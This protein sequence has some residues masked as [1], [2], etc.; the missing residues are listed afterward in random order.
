MS[1]LTWNQ[2]KVRNLMPLGIWMFI[3]G[4]AFMNFGVGVLAMQYFPGAVER[5]GFPII[6]I[7]LFVFIL[8]AN[9][10]MRKS[11]PAN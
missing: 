9:G 4:R 8:G 1:L 3:L 5:L 6:I 2:R 7:G 10:L 11:P